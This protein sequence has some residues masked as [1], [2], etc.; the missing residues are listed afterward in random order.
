MGVP[1]GTTV[2]WREGIPDFGDHAV[3]GPTGIPKAFGVPGLTGDHT[4]DRK[5]MI[6]WMASK[7]NMSKS[8][9]ESWLSRNKLR[10]HHAGG[11]NVQNVPAAIHQ[12][13]HS[14]GAQQLREG[15]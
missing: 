4:A 5:L 9:V 10:L 15:N 2:P 14:G 3:P 8:G 1:R 6:Q 12:L 7:A 13:H 11:D